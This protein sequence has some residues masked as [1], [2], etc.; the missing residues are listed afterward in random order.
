MG[1]G[2][3]LEFWRHDERLPDDEFEREYDPAELGREEQWCVLL[4]CLSS[5]VIH[6]SIF[7]FIYLHTFTLFVFCEQF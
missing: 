5:R 7:I 3:T 6:T 1:V 4:S 2:Y